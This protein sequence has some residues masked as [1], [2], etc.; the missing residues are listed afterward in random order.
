MACDRRGLTGDE[1]LELDGLH[2]KLQLLW[3]EHT[4]LDPARARDSGERRGYS[5]A[6]GAGSTG[7]K[8]VRWLAREASGWGV[9]V[10]TDTV[11][12]V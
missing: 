10:L 9:G 7:L 6:Y 11:M 5:L 2:I 4:D 3:V 1:R 8:V 12:C